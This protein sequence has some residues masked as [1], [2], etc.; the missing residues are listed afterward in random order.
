M[1]APDRI[2][3]FESMALPHARAAFNMARW[4]THNDHEA[5]DLLQEAYLRAFRYFDS[6]Q[7]QN[8]RTWFLTI[9]RNVCFDWLG[10]RGPAAAA[11]M[12]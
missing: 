12:G 5:E 3:T 9:V 6:W 11:A 7:G 10:R 4:M 8:P 2:A 1:A